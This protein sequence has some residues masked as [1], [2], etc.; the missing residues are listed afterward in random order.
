MKILLNL[1]QP[2]GYQL[3]TQFL[4]TEKQQTMFFNTIK[5]QGESLIQS[6]KKT[7]SQDELVMWLFRAFNNN[8]F[9]P[10]KVWSNLIDLRKIDRNTPLTSI[11]RSIST[12]TKEGL[13]QAT[14]KQVKGYFGK[15][16]HVWQI[17]KVEIENAQADLF[18]A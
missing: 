13:L 8:G 9:T 17:R 14:D 10:S 4:E 11:R 18:A 3:I 1:N 2:T 6:E 16:E 7:Q 15:P 5:A 12:L